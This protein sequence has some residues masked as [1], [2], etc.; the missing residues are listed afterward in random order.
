MMETVT[1]ILLVLAAFLPAAFYIFYII[2][3]D[4]HKPEPPKVLLLSALLGGLAALA[5]WFGVP[6]SSE[7]VQVEV[8]HSWKESL[9]TGFL[10]LAIPAEVAKWMLLC[11]F[12]SLNKFYDEHID[13]IVYSVCLAMG[14]AGV[15]GA[16]FLSDLFGSSCPVSTETVLVLAFLLIPLHLIAATVMGYF[17]ALAR[18]RH[19]VR[20]HLLALF[21]PIVVSGIICS[22]ALLIGNHWEYYL[23]MDVVLVILGMV[24]YTQI[25]KLLE[26][27]GVKI[28]RK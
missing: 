14:Y 17:L 6:V 22:M 5:V 2:A 8:A 27:D 18:D 1:T 3:F 9:E 28:S 15:W 25:F 23:I 26:M 16:W 19:K 13:G 10:Q 12:F 20:N 21:V 11:I 24:F 4:S 7:T